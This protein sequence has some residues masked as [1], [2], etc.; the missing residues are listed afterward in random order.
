MMRAFAAGVVLLCLLGK[1]P[2]EEVAV[3]ATPAQA[4]SFLLAKSGR[5]AGAV[6]DDRKLRLWALPEGRMLRVVDLGGR[7]IDLVAMSEDGGRIAAGDH[8]GGY[9]VWET[10]T[11]AELMHLQM[12]FYPAALAFSRDGKRLAIAP[13]GEPV[14]IYDP[15]SG[16]KLVELQRPTGGSAAVAFSRDGGR[17]ATADTDTAVRIY[18][19][20]NGEMLARNADFLLEPLAAA[21]TAEGKVLLAAGGDKFIA[22]LDTASGSVIRKS[23][24][25]IDPVTYLEVSPD[26]SFVAAMLMHA[27]NMAMPAPWLILETASGRKVQEW[28]PASLALGGGWTKEGGLLVATVSEKALHIWRVR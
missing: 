25:A 22:F 18:D 10:A 16:Q 26:G 2:S 3:L 4:T 5:L 23:A 28:L 13:V 21:F 12:P 17:I 6:C 15:A 27:A 11:G 1:Q 8:G 24:K 20:H 7:H 9:S 14:Q 19:T